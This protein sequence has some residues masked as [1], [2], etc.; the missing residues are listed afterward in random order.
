MTKLPNYLLAPI[1]HQENIPPPV[2]TRVQDLPFDKLTW[3]NF[4]RL[5]KRLV[6]RDQQIRDCRVYGKPGQ[7]QKGI[8]LIAY[9]N[10]F[11][12]KRPRVYQ[13][14][15][16]NY[17]SPDQIGKVVHK[18]LKE[19]KKLKPT[20]FVLCCRCLLNSTKQ[21]DSILAQTVLLDK[22]GIVFEVWDG[23][24]LSSV[25][26]DHP[27][28]VYD[29][30]H[31]EWVR[32]FNGPEA[33]VALERQFETSTEAFLPEQFQASKIDNLLIMKDLE[34]QDLKTALDEELSQACDKMKDIYR[35]GA[36]T[37]AVKE[38]KNYVDRFSTDLYTASKSVKAKFFHTV[39]ELIINTPS[40]LNEA[41]D[42]LRKIK[43][44][45][46]NFD[47][48]TL[49]A[50]IKLSEG[51][52]GRY[53]D[54]LSI[55]KPI[56]K[57]DVLNL[58]LAILLE[59]HKLS[60][61]Q[62]NILN[63]PAQNNDVTLQLEAYYYRF[64]GDFK[65]AEQ[66]IQKAIEQAPQYPSHYITAGH[67]AF[68][69][70]VPDYLETPA[71]LI[72]PQPFHPT[73]F[74][75]TPTQMNNFE[76][77]HNY[78]E[79]AITLI[80][81]LFP[82]EIDYILELMTYQLLCM[83]YLPQ[84]QRTA[85][86]LGKVILKEDPSNFIA[87]FY[88]IEWGIPF[89]T[90]K[91]IN[92]LED[93]RTRGQADLNDLYILTRLYEFEAEYNKGIALLL[94]DK[95]KFVTERE[96]YLWTAR[97][98][99]LCLIKGDQPC[100]KQI[101]E[102]Y[103]PVDGTLRLRLEAQLYD[104][105]GSDDKLEEICVKLSETAN[106]VLDLQN[107]CGFYRKTEKWGKLLPYSRHLI[108]RAYD[109][110]SCSLFVHTLYHNREYEECLKII[111][112]AVAL[113][114][115]GQLPEHLLNIKI[116]CLRKLNRW[117]DAVHYMEILAQQK[118]S[119]F[120]IHNLVHAYIQIGK[121]EKAIAH[122]RLAEDAPWV[123]SQL[124]MSGSQLLIRVNPVEAFRLAE[125][126]REK[127]MEDPTAWLNY[128][129]MGFLTGHDEEAS[130]ALQTFQSK[131]PESPLLRRIDLN[132]LI[133]RGKEWQEERK[134]RW[135]LFR[136]AKV[137][138]H[139]IADIER[140]PLGLEWFA[141]FQNNISVPSWESK[142]PI[143]IQ[144]G[145]RGTIPIQ[146]LDT[147]IIDYTALLVA[148]ELR[149]L[150][151]IEQAFDKI[152]IPPSLLAVIQTESLRA[153]EFQPSRLE[154]CQRIN[155]MIETGN[156]SV[157]SDSFNEKLLEDY[158]LSDLGTHDAAL[159]YLA[160]K[161]QGLVLAYHLY[162]EDEGKYELDLRLK[163]QRVFIHETLIAL[164]RMGSIS[165]QDL[166]RALRPFIGKESPR[167]EMLTLLE[168]KPL[169]ITDV[170]TLELF[171]E[172]GMLDN[173]S[174]TLKIALPRFEAN[175]IQQMLQNHQLHQQATAWLD[176]MRHHLS[177]LL[178]Q[179]YYFPSV[180][181]SVHEE[182]KSAGRC[183]RLLEEIIQI[184][185]K[186]TIPVWADDRF[187]LQYERIEQA[188]ILGTV[189]I[190]S[191][192]QK[193][194]II[195]QEDRY[196]Y[197][198]KLMERNVQFLSTDPDM[199]L[200]YFKKAYQDSAGKPKESFELKTIRRYFSNAF[201]SE[202]ALGQL[203]S[204]AGQPPETILYVMRHQGTL[205]KILISLWGD[206]EFEIEQKE[207]WSNWILHH[208]FKS[209]DE[210]GHLF[211]N[212]LDSLTATSL[213]QYYLFVIGFNILLEA[214][215]KPLES[216]S[217]YMQWLYSYYLADG[218]E[219]DPTMKDATIDKVGSFLKQMA[220]H[221]K[222][223][224]RET[225]IKLTAN[226]LAKI[227]E[228][229]TEALLSITEVELLFRGYLEKTV[230]LP[231]GDKLPVDKWRS[232]IDESLEQGEDIIIEKE[233][234]GQRFK[235]CWTALT[236]LIQG[237]RVEGFSKDGGTEARM[238]FEPFCKFSHPSVK[239]R[240]KALEE[241]NDILELTP[242]AMENIQEQLKD[243]K[244]YKNAAARIEKIALATWR[245]FW[246]RLT[247]L[248]DVNAPT[249]FEFLFPPNPS[250]F[251]EIL[252]FENSN[253]DEPEN[254]NA[255]YIK[256][257]ANMMGRRGI[258]ET[259][260]WVLSL[261][262][263]VGISPEL[264][265]NSWVTSGKITE[266]D[267]KALIL[268]TLNY[269]SNPVVLQNGLAILLPL[270]RE[271]P[272]IWQTVQATLLKL[273]QPDL[274]ENHLHLK[275]MFDFYINL[276]HF[277]WN[278]MQI[279]KAY[280]QVSFHSQ[281]IFAY[282]YAG[283]F[284]NQ[285]DRL[286]IEKKILL[287]YAEISK[288]LSERKVSSWQNAFKSTY[289]EHLEVIHPDKTSHC[290]TILGGTLNVLTRHKGIIKN[291]Y[292][293]F[294][295]VLLSITRELHQGKVAGGEEQFK[296][297]RGTRNFFSSFLN[298]NLLESLSELLQEYNRDAITA[299][300]D[301]DKELIS[302]TNNFKPYELLGGML[303]QVIE[304]KTW[305]LNDMILASIALNEPIS[306]DLI[307]N[308]QQALD[309]IELPHWIGDDK[310]YGFIC[311]LLAQFYLSTKEHEIRKG[312]F[313][314]L[315][316]AWEEK[317]NKLI[318]FVLILEAIRIILSEEYETSSQEEFFKWWFGAIDKIASPLVQIEVYELL[319]RFLW[320][321]PHTKKKEF[322]HLKEQ[323]SLKV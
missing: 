301:E 199:V 309:A 193:K 247:H 104:R 25:L 108:E 3:E 98:I 175:Q 69:Y 142:Y 42:Y 177:E 123:D 68:W 257:I 224:Y 145:G 124:L 17:L 185:Q 56:D 2:L 311:I 49:E 284:I 207:G 216:A 134:K 83:V 203:P 117:N 44:I 8:D 279:I 183:T 120:I 57:T 308:L 64:I 52:E 159:F 31:R 78:Y 174:K 240:L 41:K 205:R 267:R 192:L 151:F 143:W 102:D 11:K 235:L 293:G 7:R 302:M 152:I 229:L 210:V 81:T 86:Q 48:R 314:K 263:G 252:Q 191:I 158:Q 187:V 243:N 196:A 289:D 281:I 47:S 208:L 238:Y 262:F 168:K 128:I 164:E 153:S 87:L 82:H 222:K 94:E 250:V 18:F 51:E 133:E 4:E 126:A 54:A 14:K 239:I 181:I 228:E 170:S 77:A 223:E 285:L 118:P 27:R 95:M 137:S 66:V 122:L 131:F 256:Q 179:K 213:T 32:V 306:S 172:F 286:R 106:T 244:N 186:L 319:L 58:Y 299:L 156:I 129:E 171:F 307:P 165:K 287:N 130:L 149:L 226:L 291:N 219:A 150:P 39:G 88:H 90:D 99:E 178:N 5:C 70:A 132:A 296:L 204:I 24:K 155:G 30:F 139:M 71:S 19:Y 276:L 182:E 253:F 33:A 29:F 61:F 270:T 297:F 1:D 242:E 63:P 280:H 290:R 298:R 55:L 12:D 282:L 74:I 323:L 28:I 212:P 67:I 26:K 271:D 34:I 180:A 15:R 79:K 202:S 251:S 236:P 36:R 269:S 234:G 127:A 60:E 65:N 249:N 40:G 75:P 260:R 116:E 258:E 50:R 13:C 146:N 277:A 96:Q 278:R 160:E 304:R 261:P 22:L 221:G 268:S 169:L 110:S 154:K 97:I 201:A 265:M 283:E 62:S 220:T 35:R 245:Y 292:E 227:S 43:E 148:Y 320:T 93:K 140:I 121:T 147:V 23:E 231:G 72:I 259:M 322:T 119:A 264:I 198:I 114:P 211:P 89:K 305:N 312:V 237:I 272:D 190:L 46:P 45:D 195:S 100:A 317:E 303:N 266:K 84:K 109:P 76:K 233:Y 113:Y 112:Q 310:I 294:L 316:H 144:Y 85:L 197:L 37:E 209:F 188:A 101:L 300:R 218:W 10:D 206:S 313:L 254:F 273:L 111:D 232:W 288:W 214:K 241:I 321:M 59:Q 91:S 157:L 176:E 135:E 138:T 295:N 230:T 125:K 21:Q 80:K 166:E 162:R 163:K 16:V 246:T 161:N 53:V 105:I 255:A 315:G 107:I 184:A 194:E 73:S 6:E 215:N 274:T 103:K 173:L 217:A 225:F 9:P 115:D 248:I 318:N 167:N 20:H 200:H 141:R 189:D 136:S 275:D 38:I 92:I